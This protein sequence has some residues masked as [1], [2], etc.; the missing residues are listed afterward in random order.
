MSVLRELVRTDSQMRRAYDLARKSRERVTSVYDASVMCNLRCD[1]CLFFTRDGGYTGAETLPPATQF[2]QLFKKE[3][4]RGVNYPI[5]GGAEPGAHQEI[6]TEAAKI[7]SEGMVHTNGTIKFSKDI[8][9][10]LYV[11]SWGHRENTNKWR[12][13]DC[14]D[15]VLR[16]IAGDPRALINYTVNHANID[17][18]I[19]VVRDAAAHDVQVTFQAYSPTRDYTELLPNNEKNRHVFAR[20]STSTDNLLM[21]RADDVRANEVIHEAIDQYPDT[22]LFT[23]DL[24]AS[25]FSRPGIFFDDITGDD[26]V[27]AGCS[28]ARDTSHI[29]YR[30]GMAV[31]QDKTCG[32]PDILCK[33]CRLYTSIFTGYFAKKSESLKSRDDAREYLKAH[34][35]FWSIFHVDEL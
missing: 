5:F 17:D 16:N 15:K 22:I 18:I 8:P 19:P 23:K 26:D 4:L 21:T 6:L 7:W 20:E 11:S 28:V 24:S 33:T 12:G 9:F 3:H 25:L 14:Y 30:A 27:P 1:G 29:H 35:V 10:R 2:R 13:A 31:E 34:E 32:H